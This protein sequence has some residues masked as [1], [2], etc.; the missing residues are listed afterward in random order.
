MSH[1]GVADGRAT[2][3]RASAQALP[4]LRHQQRCRIPGTVIFRNRA[5]AY[6]NSLV[7]LF[8][9]RAPTLPGHPLG[10]W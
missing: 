10:A 7:G 5:D 2:C 8:G 9:P 3:R 6:L 1:G 4:D